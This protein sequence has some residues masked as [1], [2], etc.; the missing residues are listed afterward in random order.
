MPPTLGYT[1]VSTKAATAVVTARKIGIV[2]NT[3]IAVTDTWIGGTSQALPGLL[4][5]QNP[6]G[7]QMGRQPVTP[8]VGYHMRTPVK[9]TWTTVLRLVVI[10]AIKTTRLHPLAT[11]CVRT[12]YLSTRLLKLQRMGKV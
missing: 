11:E 10:A 12:A 3:T 4:V 8:H 6:V 7:A 1:Q 2:G 5:T 9:V